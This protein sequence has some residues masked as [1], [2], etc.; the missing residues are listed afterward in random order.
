MKGIEMREI[1]KRLNKELDE[2][3]LDAYIENLI[4]E[5]NSMPEVVFVI[6]GY[7]RL[8]AAKYFAKRSFEE[9]SNA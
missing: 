3:G 4:L 7:V 1:Y 8:N 6:E 5:G 9:K 2:L